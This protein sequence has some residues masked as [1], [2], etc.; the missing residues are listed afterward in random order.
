M[1]KK[2][3]SIIAVAGL[4]LL[5]ACGPKEGIGPIKFDNN[6]MTP[7]PIIVPTCTPTAT[8][9][10]APGLHPTVAPTKTATPTPT[11]TMAPTVTP[12]PS[13]E[14]TNTPTPSPE[15]TVTSTPT[16]SPTPSPSPTPTVNPE[17]LVNN[18]W[19]KTVSIDEK[20]QIVF[21]ELFRDSQLS[22]TDRE[23]AN[24]FYCAEDAEIEFKIVYTML[25][26]KEYFIYDILAAGGSVVEDRPEEGRT[27]CLWQ[28]G[29]RIYCE[30]LI[31]AQY[32]Q[33]LLGTAFGEEEWITGV[34][35]VVFSYPAD[36][37]DI[38]ETEQYSFYVIDNG[39]E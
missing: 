10:P 16:P 38:Y 27:T 15:P 24:V 11:A 21:P 26:T 17:P 1:K 7:T 8:P 3:I 39:E 19:Q 2:Q 34:M 4:L 12:T 18:G 5:A 9:S 13:P 30:I 31:D 37:R 23:L 36:K 20:Y 35:Q 22:K 14:P 33:Y 6:G 29:D 25:Q 28:L 32:P